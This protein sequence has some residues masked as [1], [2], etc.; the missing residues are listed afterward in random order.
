MGQMSF[1]GDKRRVRFAGEALL[2]ALEAPMEDDLACLSGLIRDRRVMPSLAD[3]GEIL[4]CSS[5]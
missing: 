1:H 2:V 3:A 4:S 5:S